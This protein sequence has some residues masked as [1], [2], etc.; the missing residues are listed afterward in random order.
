MR[1]VRVF[2]QVGAQVVETDD[3]GFVIDPAMIVDRTDTVLDPRVVEG[4]AWVGLPLPVYDYAN[5][6]IQELWIPPIMPLEDRGMWAIHPVTWTANQVLRVRDQMLAGTSKPPALQKMVARY[7][8]VAER[9]LIGKTGLIRNVVVSARMQK[10]G[11]AV[12]IPDGNYHP[13]EVGI[14][15]RFFNDMEISHHDL[16][17]IGRNPTIW[18][19]SLEVML[20]RKNPH[21]AVALHPLMFWQLGGDCDG[22]D[23]YFV[24]IPKA[25]RCQEEARARMMEF[26]YQ[27][28]TWRKQAL[29]L[30]ADEQVDWEN[31]TQDTKRRFQITGFSISPEDVM[32][33]DER[34]DVW[35]TIE[36]TSGKADL[37]GQCS[38]IAQ[39][40]LPEQVRAI[41]IEKNNETLRM[42]KHLGLIGLACN[43]M[44]VLAGRVAQWVESANYASERFQQI[45]LDSKHLGETYSVFDVLAVLNKRGKWQRA[46]VQDA[47]LFFEC[48]PD[49]EP[50][51]IRPII[52]AIYVAHPM[53]MAL[54][55]LLPATV[56]RR[57]YFQI[58]RKM[59]GISPKLILSSIKLRLEKDG[60]VKHEKRLQR[61]A[62]EYS[63]GL[64]NM[65][66]QFYP[67][68]EAI[69]S[70]K[71]KR[72]LT[73]RILH[74]RDI[75]PDGPCRQA[76]EVWH[77]LAGVDL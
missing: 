36:R 31:P 37:G 28:S 48:L 61:L 8:A 35:S 76:W 58:L 65:A 47:M 24:P 69:A 74:N 54:D 66:A 44:K 41:L 63:T 27:H 38:A 25:E 75:D 9:E 53:M 70:R 68:H 2:E 60:L 51:K 29:E 33:H 10:S 6:P 64:T 56:S 59:G 26:C 72:S 71:P 55:S 21:D 19:G 5:K 46:S 4:G 57:P 12:L 67:L 23:I 40:L 49:L 43:R 30:V 3:L 39:G 20:A 17:L 14:P 77:E 42:K 62:Y 73:K 7:Q 1:P 45:L 13:R 18:S 11:R 50:E 52:E 32:R 22:D 16:I 15:G 34:P